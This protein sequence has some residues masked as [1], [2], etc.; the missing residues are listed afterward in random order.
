M[1]V[2]IIAAEEKEMLAIKNYMT[3]ISEEKIFELNFIKGNI[4]S[5]SC[6]LIECGI[7]KVNSARTT[8][9]MIDKY[10][11]D[12]II[13]VGTAGGLT[14]D[15][16]IMDIVIGK[17]LIQHDFDITGVGNYEKGEIAGTG[18][19]FLSD[20][21]LINLC[22]NTI[23]E[24]E[25]K[26]FNIKIGRIVTGDWFASDTKKSLE[27]KEEF[28]ADCIEMEGAAIAQVCTLDNI[29]F[30]VIRGISDTLNENNEIDFHTYIENASKRVAIILKRLINKI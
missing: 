25:D 6:V 19:Y 29:P 22:E 17:D 21:R 15:L 24:L 30:L 23:K 27:I 28:D 26:S 11:P 2:G 16:K 20:D 14:S 5:K 18:K 1:V 9:L 13:N 7:G 12:Y 8:Q 3:N 4:E 10:N